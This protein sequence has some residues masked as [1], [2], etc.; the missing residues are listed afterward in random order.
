MRLIQNGIYELEDILFGEISRRRLIHTSTFFDFS[1][2]RK[3]LD[4]I[5][6]MV[7][8]NDVPAVLEQIQQDLQR[9][10]S[11]LD[12]QNEKSKEDE[13]L[14]TRQDVKSL[15]KIHISTLYNWVKSKRLKQISFGGR[16]YFRRKEI[17]D[18]LNK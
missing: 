11:I 7:T 18:L 4:S 5:N 15:F 16:V 8:H 12:N 3:L 2:D 14:L 1:F 10:L 13:T 9:V 6:K 17:M